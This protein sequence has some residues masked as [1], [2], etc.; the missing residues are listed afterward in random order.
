MAEERPE[1]AA[2][3]C[4]VCEQTVLVNAVLIRQICLMYDYSHGSYFRENSLS[5]QTSAFCIS[6]KT[7]EIALNGFACWVA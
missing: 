4:G 3:V 7:P 1:T 2:P 6:V 5:V